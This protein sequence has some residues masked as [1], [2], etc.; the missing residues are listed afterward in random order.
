MHVHTCISH[1]K[2]IPTPS[3]DFVIVYASSVIINKIMESQTE[4]YRL[5]TQNAPKAYQ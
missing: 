5:H 3:F 1:A 4:H 2:G